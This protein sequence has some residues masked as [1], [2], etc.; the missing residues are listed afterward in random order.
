MWGELSW[1]EFS[2]GRVVLGRVVFGASC[3]VSKT[4]PA[5]LLKSWPQRTVSLNTPGHR[6]ALPRH[7]RTR[8]SNISQR[9]TGILICKRSNFIW[10]L[11]KVKFGLIIPGHPKTRE[12][13]PG[14]PFK[15]YPQRIRIVSLVRSF[16][17]S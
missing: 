11:Q 16:A 8:F 1:G 6:R 7:P 9:K 15:I 12:D 3:P 5:R 2:S 14:S 17:G 4:K 13:T 10:L